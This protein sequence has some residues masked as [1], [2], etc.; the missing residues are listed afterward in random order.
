VSQRDV[1]FWD[2]AIGALNAGELER[3]YGYLDPE[4]TYYSREDEPDRL[5][6]GGLDDFKAMVETWTDMFD[7]FRCDIERTDDLGHRT[8]SVTRLRGVGTGSGAQADEPYVFLVTW[9]NGK[10]LEVHEYRT[11]DEALDAAGLT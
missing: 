6:G 8:I 9:R 1:Q 2:E 11:K 3:L 5:V 7:S 4:V 10:M